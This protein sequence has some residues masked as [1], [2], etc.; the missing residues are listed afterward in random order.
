MPRKPGIYLMDKDVPQSV[1]RFALPGLR[2]TDPDWHATVVLNQLL[3]G[4][5]FTSRL[6][7]KLRSDEGLTNGISTALAELERI[8]AAPVS[9]DELGVIKESIIQAYSGRWSK[10]Q[11]VVGAFAQENLAGW[12]ENW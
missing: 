3:G 5:G 10:K 6:M 9:E 11:N 2:R 8:K 7:K 12:P 1:V 4:S